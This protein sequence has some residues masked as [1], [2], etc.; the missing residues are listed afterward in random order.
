M[1]PELTD[2]NITYIIVGLNINLSEFKKLSAEKKKKILKK[3][4]KLEI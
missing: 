4:R 2:I 1:I 3:T